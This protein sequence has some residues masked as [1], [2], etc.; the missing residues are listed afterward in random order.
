MRTWDGELTV[1]LKHIKSYDYLPDECQQMQEI[2]D[3]VT[4][5][6]RRSHITV[7]EK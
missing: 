3:G 6:R 1:R 7:A 5:H 4:A 2:C